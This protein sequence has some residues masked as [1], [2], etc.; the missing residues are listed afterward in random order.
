MVLGT[1]SGKTA[2]RTEGTGKKT[3]CK[4]KD[5]T[6]GQMGGC[7]LDNGKKDTCMEWA[8]FNGQVESDMREAGFKAKSME[9]VLLID[10][11]NLQREIYGNR[12]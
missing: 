7:I 4:D 2:V 11:K 6:N 5:D 8:S 3:K 9:K 12:E 10:P 1:T